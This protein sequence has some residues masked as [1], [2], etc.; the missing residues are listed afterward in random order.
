MRGEGPM[1]EQMGREGADL[2]NQKSSG[3]NE[4]IPLDEPEISDYETTGAEATSTETFDNHGVDK[5]SVVAG[6]PGARQVVQVM[7][8]YDD[9]AFVTYRPSQ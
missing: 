8:F 9:N 6:N 3:L 5:E 4:D 7:L 1:Y 2:F